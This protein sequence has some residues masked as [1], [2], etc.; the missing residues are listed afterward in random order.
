[1]IMIFMK[2]SVHIVKFYTPWSMVL[3]SENVLTSM[4]FV[5]ST[6]TVVVEKLMHCY[7]VQ[8]VDNCKN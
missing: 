7:N 4:I 6:F 5:L 3:G 1:M 8:S 2:P